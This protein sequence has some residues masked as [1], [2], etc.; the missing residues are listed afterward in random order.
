MQCDWGVL[1]PHISPTQGPPRP[2]PSPSW[3][4]PKPH[5]TTA[6]LILQWQQLPTRGDFAPRGHGAKCPGT[7]SGSISGCHGC[8]GRGAPGIWQV[9]VWVLL[10]IRSARTAHS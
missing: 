10:S 4:H 2:L 8:R 5:G 1:R 6:H 9:E 7:T 3:G